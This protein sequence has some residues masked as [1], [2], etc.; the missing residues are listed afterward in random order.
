[1]SDKTTIPVGGKNVHVMSIGV[2]TSTMEFDSTTYFE[3]IESL[4]NRLVSLNTILVND[5]SERTLLVDKTCVFY[6]CPLPLFYLT[7][8]L[9]WIHNV[10]PKTPQL[11]FTAKDIARAFFQQTANYLRRQ[12]SSNVDILDAYANTGEIDPNTCFTPCFAIGDIDK[13][14]YSKSYFFFLKEMKL[15]VC[16][17]FNTGINYHNK[18]LS[19]MQWLFALSFYLIKEYATLWLNPIQCFGNSTIC[20]IKPPQRTRNTFDDISDHPASFSEDKQ[21]D[22]MIREIRNRVQETGAT[23]VESQL[24]FQVELGRSNVPIV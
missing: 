12:G 22:K 1:M 5:F 19:L 14:F 6:E 13:D 20:S 10:R 16:D 8:N 7:H 15:I 4:R 2:P 21:L 18:K 9:T 23:T 24:P 11:L 3:Y 17:S